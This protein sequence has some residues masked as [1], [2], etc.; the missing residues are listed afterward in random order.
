[1][2]LVNDAAERQALL[3]QLRQAT[4]WR[5]LGVLLPTLAH[6][7]RAPLN[8]LVVN[9][10]LLKELL[11]PGAPAD[12]QN[13]QRCERSLGALTR[14]V[15]QL[16]VNLDALIASAREPNDPEG[17]FDLGAEVSQLAAILRPQAQLQRVT[18]TPRIAEE[19]TLVRGNGGHIRHALLCLA[20]NAMEAM[21]EGG[22]LTLEV[23]Q[24]NGSAIV[25]I[26]DNGPGLS[27]QARDGLE[28]LHLDGGVGLHVTRA[29]A[30]AHGGSLKVESRETAGTRAELTVPLARRGR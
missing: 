21:K 23:G 15:A 19:K 26:V 6:D 12:A 10:E 9:L 24:A 11:K 25:S 16:R 2:E 14:A 27:A 8:A 13:E 30:E 5:A 3:G 4:Q 22:E 28:D 20:V 1:M 17:E 18:V 7:V 29:I